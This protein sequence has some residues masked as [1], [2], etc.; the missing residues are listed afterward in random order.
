MLSGRNRSPLQP[1]MKK[2]G[3]IDWLIF[4]ILSLIWGSAFILMKETSRFLDGWEVASVRIFSAG[5]VF[6][7]FAIFHIQSIERKKIPFVILTG[8]LGNLFP[9]F[10]FAI[11]IDKK[12]SSSMAGILNSLTPLFVILIAILIFRQ[13]IQSKKIAGVIVGFIGLLI[14]N[15]S[16]GGMTADN[17]GYI[18]LILIATLLYGVNVNIVTQYLKGVDPIKMATV[19]LAFMTIPA[20]I[21][22]WQ[23]GVADKMVR[24]DEGMAVLYAAAL[25]V[26]GSAIATA[27][28]YIL[29]KRAG[30]L[31]ASL[32]TYGIP[33]V[34]I[35]WGIMAGEDV[36]VIQVSCL[37]LIL[38]GV[39]LANRN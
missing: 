32:V 28:F 21:V 14:L 11:A 18:L 6:I 37:A 15:L 9:A 20:G 2:P 19:S 27:L 35:F 23:Q 17:F 1:F 22:M 16:K 12:V 29:I 13:S 10:L 4:L 5:L 26:I 3:I 30:G 34:A 38:G 31:F 39:Y 36:T 24:G 8:M 25:G 7:P 33:V